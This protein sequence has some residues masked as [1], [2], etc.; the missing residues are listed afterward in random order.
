VLDHSFAWLEQ[1][2]NPIKEWN[3]ATYGAKLMQIK[4][5]PHTNWYHFVWSLGVVFAAACACAF[6][7]TDR[8]S[9]VV[10]LDRKTYGLSRRQMELLVHAVFH[11]K[12]GHKLHERIGRGGVPYVAASEHGKRLV[13]QI[14]WEG[15]TIDE[16]PKTMRE[17]MDEP[18]T[19][20]AS[21]A[22]VRLA[23]APIEFNVHS[24]FAAHAAAPSEPQAVS[25]HLK[26]TFSERLGPLW[27]STA[28]SDVGCSE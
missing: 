14:G 20:T 2:M 12:M 3:E 25:R 21:V 10:Y 13:Y 23:H 11:E 1:N 24:E 9:M 7:E 16:K 28:A 17:W 15:E 4:G 26:L 22:H 19:T 27:A 8:N 5:L 18:R 6:A